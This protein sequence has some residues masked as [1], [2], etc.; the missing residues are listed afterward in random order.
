M[1]VNI[2]AVNMVVYIF[3]TVD[4]VVDILENKTF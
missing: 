4:K 2:L 1:V 3:G